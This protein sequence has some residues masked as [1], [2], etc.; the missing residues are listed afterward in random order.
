MI[1][2]KI[3]TFQTFKYDERS[4][5]NADILV[6]NADKFVCEPDTNVSAA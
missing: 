5:H 3:S 1:Q 4:I 2:A 6:N